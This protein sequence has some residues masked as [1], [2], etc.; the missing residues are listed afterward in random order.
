MSPAACRA[1]LSVRNVLTSKPNSATLGSALPQL[2]CT[3]RFPRSQ[4]FCSSSFRWTEHDDA[5][6]VKNRNH[7]SSDK[8][9]SSLEDSITQEKEKQTRAPWHREGSH[10]P[11]VAR[12]R[13]AGAMTKGST[14]PHYSLQRILE[15]P[16]HIFVGKLLTTPSR[17][18][19]LIIPLTT[20]DKNTDRKDVEPLALLGMPLCDISNSFLR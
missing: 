11:P 20:L 16:D 19:K 7:T 14:L 17:L 4:F 8:Q 3:S 6:A 2:T 10:L 9:D 12:P 15:V 18:L 13:S 5:A 1:A